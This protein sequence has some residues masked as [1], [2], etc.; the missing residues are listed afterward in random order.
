MLIPT[1]IPTI[2][3]L[4]KPTLQLLVIRIGPVVKVGLVVRVALVKW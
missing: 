1:V 3:A 2:E 4:D